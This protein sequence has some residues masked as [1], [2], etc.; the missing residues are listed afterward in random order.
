MTRLIQLSEAANLALHALAYLG[1]QDRNRLVS[2][3]SI[4]NTL[5]ASEAHLS[6]VL[7]M[8]ARYGLVR[9]TRGAKGGFSLIRDPEQVTLLE[10]V[11]MIDGPIV[12]ESCLMPSQICVENKCILGNLFDSLHK[13]ARQHLSQAHLSDFRFKSL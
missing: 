12:K 13:L 3:S 4:A 2:S 7:R 11:E 8:A 1:F 6:K 10:I 5:G 9:S